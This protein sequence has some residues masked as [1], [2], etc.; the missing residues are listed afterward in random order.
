MRRVT[1]CRSSPRGQEV[2]TWPSLRGET[3]ELKIKGP[4]EAEV[5]KTGEEKEPKALGEFN[6]ASFNW[7]ERGD[8]SVIDE[9]MRL[10]EKTEEIKTRKKP[11]LKCKTKPQTTVRPRGQIVERK[12]Q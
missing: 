11:Q 12:I 10:R 3:R 9:K 5:W 2:F 7:E 1:G 4:S 8:G 6:P